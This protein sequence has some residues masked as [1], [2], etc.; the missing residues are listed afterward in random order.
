MIVDP[1]VE[2]ETGQDDPPDLDT[3]LAAF[4][5][6]LVDLEKRLRR[7]VRLGDGRAAA[8]LLR[9]VA[10]ASVLRRIRQGTP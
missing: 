8:L 6:L 4:G 9:V 10:L 2:P 1:P 5:V 3:A 7:D